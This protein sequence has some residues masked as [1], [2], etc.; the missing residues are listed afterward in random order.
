[1][2]IKFNLIN[3][4]VN[5]ENYYLL[6]YLAIGTDEWFTRYCIAVHTKYTG[7]NLVMADEYH[8]MLF[9]KKQYA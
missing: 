8:G 5:D 3:L 9:A 4:Q 2:I 1:M 7:Y 6:F